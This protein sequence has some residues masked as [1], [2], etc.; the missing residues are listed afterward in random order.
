GRPASSCQRKYR[1]EVQSTQRSL[2]PRCIPLWVPINADR[3]DPGTLKN[4]LKQRPP[5]VSHLLRDKLHEACANFHYDK[6]SEK[7]IDAVKK[8]HSY[9]MFTTV[10]GSAKSFPMADNCSESLLMK[11]DVSV[12]CSNDD[13]GMSRRPRAFQAIMDTLQKRGA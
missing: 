4:I 8:E 3:A 1:T 13:L 11:R 12:W 2:S 6:F 5:K 10:K 7:K 9:W